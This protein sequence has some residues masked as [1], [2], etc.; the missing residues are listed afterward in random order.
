[1]GR[2]RAQEQPDIKICSVHDTRYMLN[3]SNPQEHMYT[4]S[5]LCSLWL[6]DARMAVISAGAADD[7]RVGNKVHSDYLRVDKINH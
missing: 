2:R 4:V 1:M 7:P 3:S 6:S 5:L